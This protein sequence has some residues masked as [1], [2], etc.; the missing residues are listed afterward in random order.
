MSAKKK[1][2]AVPAPT[3]Q[4]QGVIHDV[5]VTM[6]GIAGLGAEALMA[7]ARALEANARA[8]EMLAR[9][10]AGANIKLGP[11]IQMDVGKK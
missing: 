1:T 4:P 8:A 7:T 6:N 9:A 5:K 10:F 2:K 3:E 11:A